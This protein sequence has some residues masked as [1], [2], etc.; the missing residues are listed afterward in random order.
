MGGLIN[1]LYRGVGSEG[2]MDR[3]DPGAGRKEGGVCGGGQGK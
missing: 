2:F 1:P 3:E